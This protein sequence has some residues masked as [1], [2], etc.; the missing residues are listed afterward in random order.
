MRT[1][2]QPLFVLLLFVC[3]RSGDIAIGAAVARDV[4]RAIL[5]GIVAILALI[6]ILFMAFFSS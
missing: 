6:A 4:L 3:V 2:I 1:L 5:Y